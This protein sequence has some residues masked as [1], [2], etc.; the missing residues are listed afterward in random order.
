MLDL[1]LFRIPTFSRALSG[2]LPDRLR[3]D[4]LLPVHRPVPAARPRAVARSQAGLWSLPSAIGFIVGSNAAPRLLRYIR[5]AYLMA[6]GLLVGRDRP[7]RAGPGRRARTGW[8]SSSSRRWS[9]RSGWRRSSALT[10]ELIVGSAPPRRPA[11]PRASPRPAPSWVARSGHLDPRQHRHRHLP[12]RHRRGPARRRA[13]PA[14]PRRRATPWG[15]PIAAAAELPAASARPSSGRQRG[16]R[17][18]DAGRRHH[19][20]GRRRRRRRASSS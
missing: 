14:P 17:A 9:S 2:Q 15:R 18:G 11:P 19:Q 20:C 5:P 16:V 6:G 8:P 10:T 1:R 13:R 7:G 4:R 12:R 3:D